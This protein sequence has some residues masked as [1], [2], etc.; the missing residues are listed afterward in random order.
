DPES[1]TFT[2]AGQMTQPHA[3]HTATLLPSG[4]VLLAGGVSPNWAVAAAELYDPE[5]GTFTATGKMARARAGHAAVALAS[6]KVLVLAGAGDPYVE[7]YDPAK[8][9]FAPTGPLK[10]SG[11][12]S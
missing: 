1:G 8:G 10:H 12:S 7:L 4:Q 9:T 5:T 3:L 6:G 11:R 2:A